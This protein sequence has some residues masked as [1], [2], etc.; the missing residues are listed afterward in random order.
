M[1]L[2]KTWLSEF[3]VVIGDE[4]HLFSAKSLTTILENMDN[5]KY[6]FGLTGTLDK[7]ETNKL[8]LTG[9]FGSIIQETTTAE[10]I[11]KKVLAPLNIKCIILKYPDEIRKSVVKAEY[12]D[13][14]NYIIS[15]EYRNNFLKNLAL[16]LKGNTLMLFTRI[17]SHGDILDKKIREAISEDRKYFYVHGGVDGEERDRLRAIVEKENDAIILGS[18]GVLSTGINIKN[19]SNIIF[20]SPYKSQVKVLQ[21]IGRGLRAL[22]DKK[23]TLFD[24]ADDLSWK[25]S[26]NHTLNHFTE[27]VKIYDSQEFTYKLYFVG[28]K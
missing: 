3:E 15:N 26:R 10:L 18:F 25:K 13:E 20:A 8:V 12:Q 22:G 5:T 17:E 14:I 24:V 6:R 2:P 23:L 16:S 7:S 11:E 28:I 9:L 4:V 27:R 1:K 19:I 21:S